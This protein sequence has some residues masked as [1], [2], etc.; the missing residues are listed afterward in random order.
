MPSRPSAVPIIA[1]AP[2]LNNWFGVL[3]PVSKMMMAALL[4]FFPVMINVTRGLV[5]V[6]PAALELMRSYAASRVGGAAQAAHPEHA[7]VPLHGAEGGATLAF[8]GAIVGEFFGGTCDVLGRVVLTSIAS[9]SYDLAWAAILFGALAAIAGY[10][11]VSLVERVAIPGLASAAADPARRR[12]AMV[13]E[14]QESRPE[15]K[16]PVRGGTSARGEAGANEVERM[17]R[18]TAALLGV[19]ALLMVGCNTRP[20]RTSRTVKLQL[21]W[22][23]QAQFAGYFAADREGLLRGP[24]LEGQLFLK[25]GPDVI[26]QTVGSDPNGPEF[27]IAWVPKV[28]EVR[29]KGQSDLVD[30]AQ[31]FQRSG[32]RSVSWNPARAGSGRH[33][34]HHRPRRLQG[35]EGRR[36]GLRQR[37][38]GDRRG[39][40]EC[41]LVQ[42]QDYTQVVQ[43]FDMDAAAQP[44]DRRRRGDDLQRVRPGAR[45]DQPQDRRQL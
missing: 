14:R 6:Q 8:I 1:I 35:Q 33:G 28:L 13:T 24:G 5:E 43:P 26:P 39:A 18:S 29:A 45:G 41:G 7:A 31:V 37:V 44:R 22:A 27:T 30:I 25:G 40:Q 12:G 15:T 2:I 10:L 32:T 23:P 20:R 36:L 4:V 19:L 16:W 42:T 11:V 34:R 38:R 21:Q 17:K 9:G 3:E